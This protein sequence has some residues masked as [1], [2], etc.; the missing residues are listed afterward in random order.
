MR[1]STYTVAVV[2]TLASLLAACSD[3]TAPSATPRVSLS[4]GTRATGAALSLAP[5][6]G[7]QRDV[8]V[9]TG[10]DQIVI[11]RAQ[12]VLR[13][14]ELKQSA[15]TA[16]VMEAGDDDCEELSLGP[17]LVDLPVNAA[18]A[19]PISVAVPAGTYREIEFELHKA[20][21]GNARDQEFM[22]ANPNFA[23]TSVRVEGTYKGAPFVFV[24]DVN[25]EMEMEFN[26]PV[27]IDAAAS[28]VTVHVDVARWFVDASGAV[29]APTAENKSRVDENIK[30]SFKAYEDDD[31]DGSEN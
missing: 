24:S 13:E 31:R 29:L 11:T 20:D 14:I 4:F 8:T 12:V 10:A 2:A 17:V 16:C 15:T 19:S 9:G 3:S 18:L 22:A 23:R 21:D 30:A 25:A 6:P 1:R 26:P 28:N 7:A 27:V 5:T